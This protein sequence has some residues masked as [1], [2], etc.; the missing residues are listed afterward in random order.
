MSTTGFIFVIYYFFLPLFFNKQKLS[1]IGS[2]F[3]IIAGMCF[4]LTGITPGDIFI[5]FTD[6]KGNILNVLN[7]LSIHAFFANNIYYF[8][9]PSA[10]IYSYLIYRS[11]KIDKV[12]GL[13]YNSF[14]VLLYES[15]SLNFINSPFFAPSFSSERISSPHIVIAKL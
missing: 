13:G 1:I 2:V 15:Q 11:D 9:F 4:I 12:Y 3:A 10:F 7:M 14:S 8:A 6:Q 5:H